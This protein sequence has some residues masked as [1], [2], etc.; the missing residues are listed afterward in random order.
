[1]VQALLPCWVTGNCRTLQRSK[2][3]NDSRT[4]LP[5]AMDPSVTMGSASGITLF[6]K[7]KTAWN[8]RGEGSERG[9]ERNTLQ[10]PGAVQEGEEVL[11]AL[12][13]ILLQPV[14]QTKVRQLCPTAPHWGP[15]GEPHT[16]IQ[17]QMS[18]RSPWFSCCIQ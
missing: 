9:C 15:A 5:L 7:G 2:G 6:K 17:L 10:T 16:V 8:N 11:Q 13:L 12:E 3:L 1:M 4:D 18:E 14:V